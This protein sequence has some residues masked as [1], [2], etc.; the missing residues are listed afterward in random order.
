MGV[1]PGDNQQ[2]LN[3][4]IKAYHLYTGDPSKG[5]TGYLNYEYHNQYMETLV[6]CGL[7]GLSILLSILIYT[8]TKAIQ[9]HNI[10]LVAYLFI[11]CICF[12]TEAVLEMEIGVVG[13]TFFNYL[14]S[15]PKPIVTPVFEE[16]LLY[17]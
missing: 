15:L 9:Q 2:Y 17:V 14:L 11:F 5:T 4:K 13:F 8:F 7:I 12:L 3:D 6:G 10:L 16:P 1:S